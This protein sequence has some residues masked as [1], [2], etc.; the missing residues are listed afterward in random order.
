MPAGPFSLVG[1]EKKR[2][3]REKQGVWKIQ[4][5]D[6][7]ERLSGDRR[8]DEGMRGRGGAVRVVARPV[9]E[10]RPGGV[11]DLDKRME[12]FR[13]KGIKVGGLKR[14]KDG[15]WRAQGSEEIRGKGDRG[16]TGLPNHCSQVAD[17]LESL[18]RRTQTHKRRRRRGGTKPLLQLVEGIDVTG[19]GDVSTITL[20]PT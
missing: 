18:T 2:L 10:W 3:E 8:L 7:E 15:G 13:E 11:G 16:A 6:R 5:Q 17:T 4:L 1:V 9:V 19:G 20:K 12:G 14:G